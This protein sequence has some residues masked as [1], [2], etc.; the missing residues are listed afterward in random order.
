MNPTKEVRIIRAGD[1]FLVSIR[2]E[3]M[4][5]ALMIAANELTPI[6]A[7]PKGKPKAT[8][9]NVGVTAA[10]LKTL[11]DGGSLTTEEIWKKLAG[12]KFKGY[13]LKNVAASLS[14]LTKSMKVKRDKTVKPN[15]WVIAVRKAA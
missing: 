2:C 7:A 9:T 10:I 14:S 5:E 11:E 3:S 1:I 6:L 4:E 12:T 8:Q 13:P 15:R